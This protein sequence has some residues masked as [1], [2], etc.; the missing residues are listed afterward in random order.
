MHSFKV[1]RVYVLAIAYPHHGKSGREGGWKQ[2]L[3][4]H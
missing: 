3:V 2:I 4:D 1:K